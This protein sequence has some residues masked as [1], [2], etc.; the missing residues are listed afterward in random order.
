MPDPR[1]TLEEAAP[2]VMR[3]VRDEVSAAM[4]RWERRKRCPECAPG[5]GTGEEC[6]HHMGA[7]LYAVPDLRVIA[8]TRKFL[9]ARYRHH[10]VEPKHH[11]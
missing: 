9:M 1:A 11:A 6:M 2:L 7:R 5:Y 10:N 3:G 4:D 8:E